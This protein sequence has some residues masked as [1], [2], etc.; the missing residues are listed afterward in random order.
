MPLS[1]GQDA[2]D[3]RLPATDG[4]SYRLADMRGERSTL[5]FFSCNH[6]PYV[7]AYEDRLIALAQEFQP[8]GIGV[9]AINSNDA[10]RYP[11][12]NF[13]AMR[14]RAALKRFPFPYLHDESQDVAA[15]YAAVRTPE[16][17]VL[18]GTGKLAYHG[19]ID[20]NWK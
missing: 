8:K 2:P 1:I 16:V 15:A 5:V 4:K 6:C 17:F 10:E 18:D 9:A 11:D 19:R 20:D 12:D 14:Q 7:V 13:E 3:F